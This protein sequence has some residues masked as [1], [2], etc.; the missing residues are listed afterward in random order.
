MEGKPSEGYAKILEMMKSTKS[1]KPEDNIVNEEN[2][3]QKREESLQMMTAMMAT[4]K[5]VFDEHIKLCKITDF[6]LQVAKGAYIKVFVI[7][8]NSLPKEGNP[9]EIHAHG[10]G[11]VMLDAEMFN[12]LC[13]VWAVQKGCVVFN[14]NYRKGPET[15]CPGGQQDFVKAIE[16]VHGNA[17]SYGVNKDQILASGVSGGGWICLGACNLLAKADKAHMVKAQ[18]LWTPMISNETAKCTTEEIKPYESGVDGITPTYKLLSTDYDNQQNDDQLF[19]GRMSDALLKKVPPFAIFTS[20]FDFLRRDS[21]AL[22]E[23]G[24]KAGK[25][26]DISDIPGAG[27]GLMGEDSKSDSFKMFNAD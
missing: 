7:R 16:H 15:K 10:G 9:C 26:L 25:L 27:H 13:A 3:V 20:E 19:P 2:I 24:K 18:F 11:A 8:P 6:E 1:V 23:R 12:G 17:M 14:V 5:D 22:A 4:N 21:L